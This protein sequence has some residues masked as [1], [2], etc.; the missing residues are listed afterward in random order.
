MAAEPGAEEAGGVVAGLLV[1]ANK[2][3]A[4]PQCAATGK[5]DK[6]EEHHL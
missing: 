1:G 2:S 6:Q 4:V 5:D 3:S